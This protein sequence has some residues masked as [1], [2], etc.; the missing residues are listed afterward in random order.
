MTI[1]SSRLPPYLAFKTDDVVKLRQ[2]LEAVQREM[3][4]GTCRERM[5]KVLNESLLHTQKLEHY[6]QERKSSLPKYCKWLMGAIAV[7]QIINIGIDASQKNEFSKTDDSFIINTT[8]AVI[9]V[10]G[11]FV[12][13]HY[14][15]W[16]QD[17]DMM[18]LGDQLDRIQSLMLEF[19]QLNEAAHPRTRR[20]SHRKREHSRT[21]RGHQRKW[22]EGAPADAQQAKKP[23]TE[24]VTSFLD[25]L[26]EKK[27]SCCGLEPRDVSPRKGSRP[28]VNLLVQPIP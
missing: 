10:V 9:S 23:L 14:Q 2:Q 28:V 20:L 7:G 4:T 24:L 25:S 3:P 22:E 17:R 12:L 6:T 8:T 19:Q 1:N 21:K 11:G 5:D 26:N 16:Q 18:Q 27:S 13:N 15:N